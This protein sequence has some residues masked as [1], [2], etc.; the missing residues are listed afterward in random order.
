[1]LNQFI[2][3]I[4]GKVRKG[5]RLGREIGFPTINIPYEGEE[6]GVFVGEV[7]LKGADYQAAVHL[8]HKPTFFEEK[9]I[10]EAYLLDFDGEI[11]EGTEVE[12][13]VYEKIRD[14]K[15]FENL[16]HLAAQISKD[17]EFVKSWYNSRG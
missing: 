5:Q 8:G 13:K 16:T 11:A 17:V 15:K 14:I 6:S 9:P 1:M 4:L 12:V 3:K 2:E 10:C 7:L